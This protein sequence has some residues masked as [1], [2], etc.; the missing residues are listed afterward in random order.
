MG[1]PPDEWSVERAGGNLKIET[2]SI[3]NEVFGSSPE[4]R[5]VAH[6]PDVCLL[7]NVVEDMVSLG[8]GHAIATY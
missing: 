8:L 1:N 7:L 5:A 3:S 6:A 2:A 4:T